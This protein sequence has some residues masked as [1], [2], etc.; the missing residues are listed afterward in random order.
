MKSTIVRIMFFS[1][2]LSCSR[3]RTSPAKGFSFTQTTRS[4]LNPTQ[5]L[6]GYGKISGRLSIIDPDRKIEVEGY[7]LGSAYDAYSVF[8]NMD[9]IA[10]F[11]Q[12]KLRLQAEGE[13]RMHNLNAWQQWDR[14]TEAAALV[15]SDIEGQSLQLLRHKGQGVWQEATISLPLSE[16]E[17]EKNLVS[18][19]SNDGNM[20]VAL[21]PG[22]GSYTIFTAASSSEDMPSQATLSCKFEDS[23]YWNT[24]YLASKIKLL[25]LGSDLGRIAVVDLNSTTCQNPDDASHLQI[26][27]SVLA[28]NEDSEQNFLATT[29]KGSLHRIAANKNEITLIQSYNPGCRYSIFPEEV[30][31][32]TV[33]FICLGSSDEKSEWPNVLYENA[34]LVVYN[35]QTDVIL[36]NNVARLDQAASLTIDRTKSELYLLED[37]PFGKLTTWNWLTNKKS[38]K[39]GLFLRNIL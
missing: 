23:N 7:Q 33:A 28:I 4:I 1:L 17:D 6:V 30:A 13:S 10:L 36:L 31:T 34:N 32:A 15:F 25:L 16:A 3:T 20:I 37:T 14:A 5:R 39:N 9:G 12:S 35:Y 29:N 24:A 2:M 27:G 19:I 26:E 11:S 8:P 21:K 22:Y 18:L 38:S